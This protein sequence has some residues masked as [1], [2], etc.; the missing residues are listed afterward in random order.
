M[1]LL[2]ENRVALITGSASGMGKAMA[3]RF[4]KEGCDIVVAD[5]NLDGAKKASDEV[6]AIG[7]KA[8]A[9]RSDIS[10]SQDIKD[11]IDQSIREFGKIDILINNAGA[12]GGGPLE[13]SDEDEWDRVL[14]LN[15]KG[16]FLTCKAAVP[17]MKKQ[18]YGKIINLSSMGAVR[19]SVSVLAYHS[20]KA[21]II[22]LTRNLAFELAP[23]NIYVNCIVPG[24]IETPFWDPL[25]KGLSA[26][27]KRAFFD[28]LAK[29]EVPLGRMGTPDDIAGP[30]LFFASELSS[31]VTGQVLCVAGGQPGITA[32][33]T[34]ISSAESSNFGKL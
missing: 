29:K 1:Q 34:F 30:A 16:A 10:S 32:E 12:A 4:A 17:H 15:L 19:P 13:A 25:S 26:G 11:L 2:L 22:G 14:A 18:G 7:R 21:G 3:L 33:M 27:Q 31:Y 28:A 6:R 9:I 24:P 20:A 23:F 5:L 8:Y